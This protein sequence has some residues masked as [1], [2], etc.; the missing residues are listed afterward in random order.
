MPIQDEPGESII[1][2]KDLLEVKNYGTI[3][4][5]LEFRDKTYWERVGVGGS[6]TAN[7]I[8]HG[9]IIYV[10]CCD[11]NFY[12]IDAETGREVWRFPTKG[13]VQA[14]ALCKDGLVF[15]G[16]ADRNFYCLDSKTG[17]LVWKYETNGPVRNGPAEHKGMILVGSDDGC[18]YALKAGD[19]SFL[20]KFMTSYPMTMPLIIDEKIYCGYE[21]CSFYCLSLKGELLWK[22][23]TNAWIAA[24]PAA[25]D[26]GTIYFG[27]AD[28]NLYA[29]SKDGRLK[30]KF[31]AS[32]IVLCPSAENS[33]VYFGCADKNIY[34]LDS[35]GKKIW[36]LKTNEPVGDM[37]ISGNVL[38][39]GCYDRNLYA[40][41]KTTRKVLWKFPTDGFVHCVPLI[42][43]NTVI[44]GS[45][46]CN[47]Y[48]L[49]KTTGSLVWKFHSSLSTQ[50]EIAPPEKVE[51][52]KLGVV[53][54]EEDEKKDKKYVSGRSAEYEANITT[55]T[56]G[57]SKAYLSSRKKGYVEIQE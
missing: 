53:K 22:F 6:F 32:D 3:M 45:W 20:W 12:A 14:H 38:Y 35:A 47:L 39:M 31:P 34:C 11:K 8:E 4:E 41:E 51:I 16:S 44:F 7:P 2:P 57:I 23:N 43:G 29:L 49:D 27:S 46:D 5:Y 19:G 15:F 40:V 55:Y 10:G 13:M 17:E 48:C 37:T 1:Q 36:S 26:N 33:R 50:S 56:G 30:W 18:L 54:P 25:Y 9:G 21:S 28:K 42:Y 24:W 52:K